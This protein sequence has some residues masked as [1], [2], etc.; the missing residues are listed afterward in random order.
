MFTVEDL[1]RKGFYGISIDEIPKNEISQI[2]KTGK[3]EIVTPE[4]VQKVKDQLDPALFEVIKNPLPN[5]YIRPTNK[6][7]TRYATNGRLKFNCSEYYFIFHALITSEA[8]VECNALRTS[9]KI[10][11][12]SFFYF[13]K[14]LSTIGL[15]KKVDN[16]ISLTKDEP[17]LKEK[18]NISDYVPPTQLLRNTPIYIQIKRL[19]KRENGIS[20]QEIQKYLGMSNRKAHMAL[21]YVLDTEFSDNVKKI[22]EF[23]G[24]TRRHRYIISKHYEKQKKEFDMRD[25]IGEGAKKPQND[26]INTEMRTKA[27]ENL[28]LD[29]KAVVYNKQ[30]HRKLSEILG[31]K[32]TI[33]KNTVIR[34]ANASNVINMV[35]VYLNYPT[36]TITRNIFKVA[37]IDPTD[38]IVIQSIEKEG[39]KR[40]SIVTNQGVI[41]YKIPEK[42]E[43]EKESYGDSRNIEDH[44]KYYKRVLFDIYDEIYAS[45]ENGYLLCK[46]DRLFQLL[47]HWKHSNAKI[48]K[49]HKAVEELKMS[50]ILAIFSFSEPNLSKKIAEYLSNNSFKH[51]MLSEITY[52]EFRLIAPIELSRYFTSKKIYIGISEY[53]DELVDMKELEEID[54]DTSTNHIYRIVNSSSTLKKRDLEEANKKYRYKYFLSKEDR[55][56]LCSKMCSEYTERTD[57]SMSIPLLKNI[58]LGVA[59]NTIIGSGFSKIVKSELSKLFAR[60]LPTKKAYILNNELMRVETAE[61]S[62]LLYGM[63]CTT[64][65]IINRKVFSPQSVLKCLLSI[66]DRLISNSK[67]SFTDLEDDY[68]LCEFVALILCR[69]KVLTFSRSSVKKNVLFY[70]RITEE[71]KNSLSYT[72]SL[73]KRR[74]EKNTYL[75]TF[76]IPFFARIENEK[77]S[78]YYSTFM[79]YVYLLHN[80]ATPVSKISRK[81]FITIMEIDE[82]VSKYPE[83]FTIHCRTSI[84]Q[85]VISL[86]TE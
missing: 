46:Q 31:S 78:I 52:K 6:E 51:T 81:K 80:G 34:T 18:N 30:F 73:I 76:S 12:K 75:Q 2:I 24:K 41:D 48:E 10:G 27:I 62:T 11:A 64:E 77:N 35:Q 74:K 36:K 68:S 7:F 86:T 23:E 71:Y 82:I 42:D 67:L 53:I 8:P 84:S 4:S 57:G 33:D 55:A 14:K 3:A 70:L 29:E 21:Q 85:Y 40:F 19:I 9:L 20:T 43:P 72:R 26:L 60:G 61:E 69:L 83:I 79:L 54:K 37:S 63:V 50:V 47:E 1:C 39:Y 15:V 44:E 16:R 17:V 32:H 45:V 59:M 28:V 58:R 38:P 65:Y 49:S 25:S 5:A 13:I 66:K 22:T 56:L